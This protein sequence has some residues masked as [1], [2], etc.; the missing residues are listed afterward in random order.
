MDKKKLK[1]N[2]IISAIISFA[3]FAYNLTFS[4][5][6]TSNVMFVASVSTLMVFICKILFINN[7]FE[8]R[9]NKKKAYLGMAIACLSYTL[10]FILFVVLKVNGID[11]SNKK[12]YEGIYGA[13]FISILVIMFILSI[14]GLKGALGKTD[15]M[16]TGLK[17]ITFISGLANLVVIEEFVSRIILQYKEINLMKY[18][19]SYFP[20]GISIFMLIISILMIVR[21]F[22]YKTTKEK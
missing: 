13:I 20:L 3:I 8:K 11:A 6:T 18:V 21:F 2:T 4:I 14:I 1:R 5:L 16:V 7:I 19:D 22:R 15:I 17:E 10:I 12:T 9:T